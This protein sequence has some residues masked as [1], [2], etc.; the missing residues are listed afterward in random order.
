VPIRAQGIIAVCVTAIHPFIA[1]ASVLRLNL[2]RV[3]RLISYQ[4]CK[5][6]NAA[7]LLLLLLML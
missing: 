6:N 5:F 7:K 4:G 2:S 3:M 1:T